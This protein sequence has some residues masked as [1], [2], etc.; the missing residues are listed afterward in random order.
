MHITGVSLLRKVI[1]EVDSEFL[2]SLF[3]KL[4]SVSGDVYPIS[5]CIHQILNF[6]YLN[7]KFYYR[8]I[9]LLT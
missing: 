3:N 7:Y 2:M 5:Q 8:L 6:V 9:S 1:Q 4:M